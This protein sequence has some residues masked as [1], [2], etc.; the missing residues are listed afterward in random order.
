LHFLLPSG[1]RCV[2]K[3]ARQG[4]STVRRGSPMNAMNECFNAVYKP[5]YQE[6]F[7]PKPVGKQVDPCVRHD[8]PPSYPDFAR[9]SEAVR[10]PNFD[11]LF[12]QKAQGAAK[13]PHV[14]R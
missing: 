8:P 3:F 6:A 7:N 10:S 14:Q 2:A 1:K 13:T 9:I 12:G 4:S 5:D 11:D